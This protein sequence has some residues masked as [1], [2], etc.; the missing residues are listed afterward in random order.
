M[1]QA[2]TLDT[3]SA[4]TET[5]PHTVAREPHSARRTEENGVPSTRNVQAAPPSAEPK[6]KPSRAKFVALALVLL[7]AGGGGTA[8]AV[9]HGHETTDDAQVEGHVQTVAART[10]GQVAEVLVKDND[11]V[12]E[13]Q[14]VA[15][16]DKTDLEAKVELAKADVSSADAAIDAAK[17]QLDLTEQNTAATLKQ[18]KGGLKQAS[19]GLVGSQASVDQAKADV[20]SADSRVKLAQVDYDRIKALFDANAVSRAELDSRSAALDQ[21]NANLSSARARLSA[22]QASIAANA[23]NLELA[24]GRLSSAETGPAQLAAAKAAVESAEARKKQADASLHIAEL[25]LGYADVRAPVRGI[26][27]KRTVEVGQMASPDRALMAIVPLD[28]VWVVANFKETQLQDMRTGQPVLV[29]VDAFGGKKLHGHVDSFASGTGS[30]FSLLPP[31][32]SSGN[33]VKV[34]QRVPT[35]IRIDGTPGLELRPGM[36][37]SVDVTTK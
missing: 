26:V 5:T 2:A 24:E 18:A 22:A 11:V 7:A 30:K 4:R 36:S 33:F 14:I 35:L 29:E 21:A 17:A 16:L 20:D 19:G 1:T 3:L 12:E 34:V 28:D 9:S 27:S 8:Y 23:G 31:D 13:G 10:S 25:N 6:K 15:T 32:N 37:V